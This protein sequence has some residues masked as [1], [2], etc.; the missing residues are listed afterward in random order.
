MPQF[1]FCILDKHRAGF[2]HRIL[3]QELLHTL[4]EPISH[5][6]GKSANDLEFC[7]VPFHRHRSNKDRIGSCDISIHRHCKGEQIY[8]ELLNAILF[9]IVVL[10]KFH[11]FHRSDEDEKVTLHLPQY[12]VK[13]I[14]LLGCIVLESSKCLIHPKHLVEWSWGFRSIS[15]FGLKLFVLRVF[16]IFFLEWFLQ[17]LIQRLLN[18]L[19]ILEYIGSSWSHVVAFGFSEN[20]SAIFLSSELFLNYSSENWKCFFKVYDNEILTNYW[21]WLLLG[22]GNVLDDCWMWVY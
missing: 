4:H 2:C 1:S 5:T 20:K 8:W 19:R 12:R 21:T 11:S 18:N 15:S 9:S 13:K 16:W 17:R 7:V 6:F 14:F 22:W 3:L 10:Q